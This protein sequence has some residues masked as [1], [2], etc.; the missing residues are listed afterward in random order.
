MMLIIILF[1]ILFTGGLGGT[2]LYLSLF[3]RNLQLDTKEGIHMFLMG[4]FCLILS[5]TFAFHVLPPTLAS[6]DTET[7]EM[8]QPNTYEEGFKDGMSKGRES[9]YKEILGIDTLIN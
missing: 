5:Y 2:L 8:E 1:V 9:V 7:I 3:S 6:I 4:V